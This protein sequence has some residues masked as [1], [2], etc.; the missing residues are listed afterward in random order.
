MKKI[1]S[2]LLCTQCGK[3]FV[4]EFFAKDESGKHERESWAKENIRLCPE[5]DE[6]LEQCDLIERADKICKELD[7][8]AITG[9]NE[10]QIAYARK[11]RASFI[12][13]HEEELRDMYEI[14]QEGTHMDMSDMEIHYGDPSELPAKEQFDPEN[15]E[16]MMDMFI[17]MDQGELY[18]MFFSGQA[19]H[20]VAV[21]EGAYG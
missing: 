16:C 10:E 12:L 11:L 1:Y 2:T 7:I 18:L 15:P 19:E 4:Y 6:Y 9:A 20:L 3:P 21:L 14:L 8:P 13:D 17:A 5:C